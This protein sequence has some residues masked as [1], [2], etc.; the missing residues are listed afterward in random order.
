MF[1]HVSGYPTNKRNNPRYT[2]AVTTNILVIPPAPRNFLNL[3]QHSLRFHHSTSITTQTSGT[4]QHPPRNRLQHRLSNSLCDLNNLDQPNSPHHP[5][6]PFTTFRST[7]TMTPTA[8][9][10]SY[11]TSIYARNLTAAISSITICDPNP[12]YIQKLTFI[13]TH[14]TTSKLSTVR[15]V[16]LYLQLFIRETTP[17]QNEGVEGDDVDNLTCASVDGGMVQMPRSNDVGV[18]Q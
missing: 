5:L 10:S 14:H 3:Q 12:G 4:P 11:T 17:V 8:T 9:L 15:A 16:A 13:T 18:K 1:V 2:T 7:K 6:T